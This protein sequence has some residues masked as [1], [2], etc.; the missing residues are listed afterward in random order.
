MKK[1]LL[2][3]I[4]F[5]VLSPLALAG[6]F[7]N[8]CN[9]SL[10]CEDMIKNKKVLVKP[11]GTCQSYVLLDEQDS[12][13]T[14]TSE[15]PLAPLA[16]DYNVQTSSN[17]TEVV[18]V[19]VSWSKIRLTNEGDTRVEIHINAASN[20]YPSILEPKNP[21]NGRDE[22]IISNNYRIHTLYLRFLSPTG[23]VVKVEEIP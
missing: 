4:F 19:E 2:F 10:F 22:L 12:C 21:D 5:L 18:P 7:R 3:L 23:G 6:T 9:S 1:W 15:L 13:W 17:S 16:R 14:R 11:G 8:D 20:P